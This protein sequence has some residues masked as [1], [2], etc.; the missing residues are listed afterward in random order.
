MA[1]GAPRHAASFFVADQL[2]VQDV[3]VSG[4]KVKHMPSTAVRLAP[5]DDVVR[6]R[7]GWP[8]R[9]PPGRALAQRLTPQEACAW[10]G[11]AFRQISTAIHP[12][13]SLS[14]SRE[15]CGA[16]RTGPQ[17]GRTRLRKRHL[18]TCRPSRATSAVVPLTGSA[19]CV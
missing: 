3:V 1:R 7:H 18:H 19:G 16:T 14:P 13:C 17:S 8:A 4:G 15:A 10:W 2:L 9:A 11:R 6:R 12:P 5:A